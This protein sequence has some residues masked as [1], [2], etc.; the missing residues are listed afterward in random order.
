[1]DGSASALGIHGAYDEKPNTVV[2]SGTHGALEGLVGE[3]N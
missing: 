1:M 3:A 2:S